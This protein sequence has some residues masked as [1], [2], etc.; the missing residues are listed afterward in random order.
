MS[1]DHATPQTRDAHRVQCRMHAEE[2]AM[3]RLLQVVRIRG[4]QLQDLQVER[5][6]DGFRIALT[7][8]GE[9]SV[10]FLLRQL[11]KLHTVLSVVATPAV[12]ATPSAVA[13]TG[14]ANQGRTGAALKTA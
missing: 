9:R 10:D 7:V 13:T 3:E 11:E 14:L 2:A 6:G 5:E 8:A 1:T 4:F 12:V